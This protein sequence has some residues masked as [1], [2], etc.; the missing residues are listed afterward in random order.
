[1]ASFGV[2]AAMSSWRP[3]SRHVYTAWKSE[4]CQPKPHTSP[5]RT[6]AGFCWEGRGSLGTPQTTQLGQQQPPAMPSLS[7]VVWSKREVV[8]IMSKPHHWGKGAVQGPGTPTMPIH[9]PPLR[10][11][12]S[13]VSFCCVHSENP[14]PTTQERETDLVGQLA[15][16]VLCSRWWS[17]FPEL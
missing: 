7:L 11:T 2:K 3:C 8:F 14:M 17:D 16:S 1:M 4:L 9:P 13:V 12:H 6:E 15:I 10:I 5:G